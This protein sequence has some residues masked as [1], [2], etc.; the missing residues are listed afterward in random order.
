MPDKMEKDVLAFLQRVT[1]ARPNEIPALAW[2][3]IYIVVLFLAYYVLRPIR[4]EM[5]VA[6]G[7]RNLP[8]LFTG[9]L[10]A[11]LVMSP[12][13]AYAVRRFSRDRF[14]AFCYRFFTANLI[15]FAV[16]LATTEPQD[17]VWIGRAFFVWVSVFNLF[18]VSVFWSFIV[19]VFDAEQG[20]RLFGIIAAGATLGGLIGS[21]LTSG[22]IEEIGRTGL[23]VISMVL[24]EVAVFAARS[25]SRVSETFHKPIK[26]DDPGKP[27]GGGVFAG[28]AHTFRSPYLLG[29]GLFILLYSVT[30][31]FLYFQQASIAEANFTDRAARTAFFA[32]IDL[33]VNGITLILQL[34]VTGWL[35]SWLGVLVA[36]CTLPVVSI[37]G[38]GA[39]AAYPS[40]A[41]FV[42]AQVVRRVSN[43]AFARPTRE[44][45]FTSSARED[46][47]KAK[48]F[49]DTV[50]YRGGDQ[51]G[52]WSYGG[53]MGLGFSITQISVIAVPLSLVWLVL[54][55]FLARTH[56]R[57]EARL[58]EDQAE[59]AGRP[60]VARHL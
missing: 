10:A 52:S 39:L 48:N 35:M 44:V 37:L 58:A 36:L 11:M 16:L 43:F 29:L 9:T 13:F 33:W 38:F 49:I 59:P 22:L 46:R 41:V 27:L 28:M 3:L 26:A 25:L 1:G 17:Q 30:S 12:L 14:I 50:I 2:S 56:E 21:A 45:L 54:S 24:L 55:I 32:G 4:D 60:A 18:V 19:D 15:V 34:F 7:V 53:L 6:G 23:L 20:K 31:T 8:W 5:G 42:A 40:V 57:A 47:Y 51:V